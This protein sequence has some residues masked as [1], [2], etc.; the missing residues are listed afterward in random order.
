MAGEKEKAKSRGSE[1]V[2]KRKGK[3]DAQEDMALSRKKK[4]KETLCLTGAVR[5][6]AACQTVNDKRGI[7]GKTSTLLQPGRKGLSA[8][9]RQRDLNPTPHLVF[10]G[11][12]SPVLP[13]HDTWSHVNLGMRSL[14]G[15]YLKGTV[16]GRVHSSCRLLGG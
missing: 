11:L 1:K 15:G 4:R 5:I 3:A 13:V 8:S 16:S 14:S 9:L 6:I 12:Y 2:G 10:Q 7:L